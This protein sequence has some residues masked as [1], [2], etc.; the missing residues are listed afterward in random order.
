MFTQ[1]S[2]ICYY[3]CVFEKSVYVLEMHPEIIII[4]ILHIWDSLHINPVGWIQ[5][6]ILVYETK[7]I[8]GLG[9]L[10]LFNVL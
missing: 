9:E 2:N 6:E 8:I 4:E 1:K 7:G 5:G 3:E 10:W